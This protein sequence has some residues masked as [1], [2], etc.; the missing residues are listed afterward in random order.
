[1]AG[2][3]RRRGAE[4]TH[5]APRPRHAPLR[6]LAPLL[7]ASSLTHSSQAHA[8]EGPATAAEPRGRARSTRSGDFLVWQAPPGCSSAA[9]LHERVRELIGQPELDL[10]RVQRVEGRVHESPGGWTLQLRL[11][12][13]LG[14]RERQLRAERC[15]DLAEAA[16]VA[17]TLAFESARSREAELASE[18]AASADTQAGSG[19]SDAPSSDPPPHDTTSDEP[20]AQLPEPPAATDIARPD[21]GNPARGPAPALGAEL[22]VD[23]GTLPVAAP[24]VTVFGALRWS[25]L[26]L[27][28]YGLWLPGADKAVGPAQSVSFS[29][30]SGGLRAGYAIGHGWV[31]TALCAGIEAG[32]VAAKG[33][34]LSNARSVHDLW[35]AAHAGLQLSAQPTTAL[36]L[37]IRGEAL[38]PLLRQSYAVNDAA[39]LD[40]EVDTIASIGARLSAGAMLTF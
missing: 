28:A 8:S 34:G 19:A 29:L 16:A 21:A 12:D 35:L 26:E 32:R 7:L 37:F 15:A 3:G 27:A 9:A 10:K 18:S 17:I 39:T 40:A 33:A 24:G 20:A 2:A 30:V 11:I 4:R 14:P 31:D 6:W 1:V 23:L 36:A 38:V 22:V 5:A 25:E 13:A